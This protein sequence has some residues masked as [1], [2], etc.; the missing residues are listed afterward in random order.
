M[1]VILDEVFTG[2]WRLGS[3]TA[4][5]LLRIQADIACYAKLLTGGLVPLAVTLA[6]EEV[7]NAFKGRLQLDG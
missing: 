3:P 7:F 6:T 5:H 1:P 2:F 4:A